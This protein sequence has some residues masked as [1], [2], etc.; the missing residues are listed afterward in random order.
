MGEAPRGT[1]ENGLDTS[2][3]EP[4]NRLRRQLLKVGAGAGPAVLALKGRSA[5]AATG[6]A[7]PSFV[8]SGNLSAAQTPPA[9]CATGFSPGYWKVCQHLINWKPPTTAPT[10]KAGTCTTGMPDPTN[11][12]TTGTLFGQMAPFS[13]SAGALATY[14]AWRILAYPTIVDQE[15]AQ[16]NIT[17][18]QLARHLIATYL[19]L[20]YVGAGFPLTQ[21]QISLMWSQGVF[22]QYCPNG[23]GCTAGQ[24]WSAQTIVCYLRNYTMDQAT[25]DSFLD[26]TC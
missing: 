15:L 2:S 12:L 13:G 22:G 20:L 18:V 8:F 3:Q 7:S 10:F 11:Q 5:L 19:N 9:G 25:I 17:Q 24:L 23:S 16:F 4:R 1:V 21:T 14:G 26:W 6:C